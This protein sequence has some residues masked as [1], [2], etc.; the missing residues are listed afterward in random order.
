[1]VVCISPNQVYLEE[2]LNSI[3]Y[4]EKAKKIK[5]VTPR[6]LVIIT[7]EEMLKRRIAE[8]EKE[9]N[10][11]RKMLL[12]KVTESSSKSQSISRH[13]KNPSGPKVQ[14]SSGGPSFT[15]RPMNYSMSEVREDIES[16]S[17]VSS[18]IAKTESLIAALAG[19]AS[20]NHGAMED[21]QQVINSE[22]DSKMLNSLYR[23]LQTVTDT[24]E[25]RTKERDSLMEQ[26]KLLRV[27]LRQVKL[28]VL[29]AFQDLLRCFDNGSSHSRIKIAQE[30]G[31]I[32]PLESIEP[33]PG[34]SVKSGVRQTWGYLK[35]FNEIEN[36]NTDTS[37]MK[38]ELL[39][40]EEQIN[41]LTKAL[42]HL[43]RI[44]S[45][46]QLG[47]LSRVG[48]DNMLADI[49]SIRYDPKLNLVTSDS[50]VTEKKVSTIK[51]SSTSRPLPDLIAKL[52][53]ILDP[54]ENDPNRYLLYQGVEQLSKEGADYGLSSRI[55]R[56]MSQEVVSQNRPPLKMAACGSQRVMQEIELYN[57][58]DSELGDSDINPLSLA[59]DNAHY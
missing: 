43:A 3:G 25:Q 18:E 23:E 14:T 48:L 46:P 35:E 59:E 1:M 44:P 20:E 13:Q 53:Q 52:S 45:S 50:M 9:N 21:L 39:K 47:G 41:E 28:K 33:I 54:T 27:K 17:D 31:N 5:P 22:R 19:E 15:K 42:K 58:Q 24:Y 30:P 12:G 7:P 37:W 29:D 11:L 6:Q 34:G 38:E 55:N 16:I 4:A 57:D 56:T 40:K 36:M 51:G 2:T 10:N 49:S 8:L 32:G 26:E